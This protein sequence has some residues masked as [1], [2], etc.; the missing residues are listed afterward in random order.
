ML[1]EIDKVKFLGLVKL[2]GIKKEENSALYIFRDGNPDSFGSLVCTVFDMEDGS[3]KSDMFMSKAKLGPI[4]QKGKTYCKD[5][6][7][8]VY[9]ARLKDWLVKESG[10]LFQRYYYF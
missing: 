3:K 2:I 8:T 7:S 9:V 1:L 10:L 6:D 5:L 4:I